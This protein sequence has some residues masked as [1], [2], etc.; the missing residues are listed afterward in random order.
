MVAP[1]KSWRIKEDEKFG[2][3]ERK[4]I[5]SNFVCVCEMPIEYLDAYVQQAVG[6]C[7]QERSCW[8]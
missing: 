2:G 1:L 5:N 4:M 6:T 7:F 8:K 3:R